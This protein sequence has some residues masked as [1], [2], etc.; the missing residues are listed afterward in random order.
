MWVSS[1]GKRKNKTLIKYLSTV[2]PAAGLRQTFRVMK[3]EKQ[4]WKFKLCSVS[5]GCGNGR[6]CIQCDIK[7]TT[8]AIS[9]SG[10]SAWITFWLTK[11]RKK[12]KPWPLTVLPLEKSCQKPPGEHELWSVILI[13][14]FTQTAY[15]KTLCLL[16]T[17]ACTEVSTRVFIWTTQRRAPPSA[18]SSQAKTIRL[19]QQ[20][21]SAHVHLNDRVWAE[22]SWHVY[23]KQPCILKTHTSPE[24]S[25]HTNYTPSHAWG[26]ACGQTEMLWVE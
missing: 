25:L 21:L 10:F 7:D 24:S 13:T 17:S 19:L 22:T 12:K 15:I 3:P 2:T 23:A 4:Q 14:L 16:S 9:K 18:P 8:S 26:H 1:R 20:R 6:S 11:N 5:R